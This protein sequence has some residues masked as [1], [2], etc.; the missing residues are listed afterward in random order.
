V[1]ICIKCGEE[2]TDDEF[3]LL[4][5]KYKDTG[6]RMNR[7]K[8]CHNAVCVERQRSPEA[9][10]QI[11]RWKADNPERVLELNRKHSKL[12]KQRNPEE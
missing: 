1:K 6:R 4:S 9:K 3:Y 12:W 5:G 8:S 2:K 7:C 10:A 11:L